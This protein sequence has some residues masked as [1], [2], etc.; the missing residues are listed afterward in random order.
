MARKGP[1]RLGVVP[2][3]QGRTPGPHVGRLRCCRPKPRAAEIIDC[4][5]AFEIQTDPAHLRGPPGGSVIL[6]GIAASLRLLNAFFQFC[7]VRGV[8]HESLGLDPLARIGCELL[9]RLTIDASS[10]FVVAGV[11][12]ALTAVTP[13]TDPRTIR[14]ACAPELQKAT[15]EVAEAH[16]LDGSPTWTRTRDPRI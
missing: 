1:Y 12:I 3:V 6:R 10:V 15:A 9:R 14:P 4:R 2:A 5:P 8:G 11:P 16:D 13:A 7:D